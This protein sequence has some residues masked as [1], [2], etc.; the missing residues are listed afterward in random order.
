VEEKT[1][2]ASGSPSS[3]VP[4]FPSYSSQ[5]ENTSNPSTQHNNRQSPTQDQ[6]Q[7]EHAKNGGGKLEHGDEVT[8]YQP[9]IS[10]Q[11]PPN[12]QDIFTQSTMVPKSHTQPHFKMNESFVSGQDDH[13]FDDLI[14]ENL[15]TSTL[16]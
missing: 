15:N 4:I 14:D 10:T 8:Q 16:G 12:T 3:R 9:S 5:R 7:S 13:M 2:K 11:Y 6:S 1:E